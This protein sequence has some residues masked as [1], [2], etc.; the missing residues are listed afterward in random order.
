MSNPSTKDK[1][2]NAALDLFSENGYDGTSVDSIAEAAGI[3]G[4]SLYK[5]FKGK[6]EILEA[7]LEKV[8]DYYNERFVGFSNEKKDVKALIP[9][10]MEELTRMTLTRIYFT[11]HDPIIQKMRKTIAIE[12]F[13]NERFA[14]LANLHHLEG[15]QEMFKKIFSAMMEANVLVKENA[16]ILAL[17]YI[18]PVTL[19]IQI[20]DRNPSKEKDVVRLIRNHL[21]LFAKTYENKRRIFHGAP[22]NKFSGT[23]VR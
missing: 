19:L 15:L 10:S 6:N 13:R 22:V 17:E 20:F 4:P 12:Q 2:L 7:M 18:A 5:H 9:E 14:K 1:I 16:D 21:K 8:N 3:K 23:L 11:M